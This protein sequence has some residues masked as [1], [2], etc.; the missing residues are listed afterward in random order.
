MAVAVAA[1]AFLLP[2]E[3]SL[4]FYPLNN[5][6]PG[7]LLVQ[8]TCASSVTGN[9]QFYLDTGQGFNERETI[10]WPIAPTRQPYTYTF[11]LADAPLC[12][13]RIDPFDNGPGEFTITNLRIIERHG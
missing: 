1:A 5:P 13:L 8:I 4:V 6:S 11:P 12:G 9:T 10:T 2:Q 7:T 3:A